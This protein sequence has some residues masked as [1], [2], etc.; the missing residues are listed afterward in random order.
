MILFNSFIYWM[1]LR[2]HSF[3]NRVI[4]FFSF[5][6]SISSL[7]VLRVKVILISLPAG[8]MFCSFHL[9]LYIIWFHFSLSL[10]PFYYFDYCEHQYFTSVLLHMV[11]F[12]FFLIKMHY[13]DHLLEYPIGPSLKVVQLRRLFD[14]TNMAAALPQFFGAARYPCIEVS[15]W[16][17]C[18]WSLLHRLY[19]ALSLPT[20][21]CRKGTSA[22]TLV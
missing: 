11:F 16:H 17:S 8:E 1:Y 6:L 20:N 19:C 2:V 22:I 4:Y 10:T 15:D 14:W 3:I 18:F 12:F 7:S 5:Y 13:L 9:I 21:I